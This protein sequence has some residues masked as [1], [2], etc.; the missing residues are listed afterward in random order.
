MMA[1]RTCA[2]IVRGAA[3]RMRGRVANDNAPARRSLVM[4]SRSGMPAAGVIAAF[5]MDRELSWREGQLR[6]WSHPHKSHQSDY[7]D[8]LALVGAE[9]ARPPALISA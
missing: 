5:S 3:T 2:H 7:D 4:Q 6:R 8:L 1:M 9:M